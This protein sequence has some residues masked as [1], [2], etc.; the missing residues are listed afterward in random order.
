MK[1]IISTVFTKDDLLE[2]AKDKMLQDKPI[3]GVDIE[4]TQAQFECIN[5]DKTL[6]L[7]TVTLVLK[8]GVKF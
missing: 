8:P 2:M 6:P 1:T 5:Q 4:D 3:R 7:L